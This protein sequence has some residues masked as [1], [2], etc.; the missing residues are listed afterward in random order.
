MDWFVLC[1]LQHALK[2]KIPSYP[3]APPEFT[4]L[5]LVIN[6]SDGSRLI[7]KLYHSCALLLPTHDLKL[8]LNWKT[9]LGQSLTDQM[10]TKCCTQTRLFFFNHRHKLLHFKFLRRAYATLASMDCI[11]PARTSECPRCRAMN[12]EF[13]HKAWLC[14]GVASFWVEI[15]NRLTRLLSPPPRYSCYWVMFKTFL[16]QCA[17]TLSF[18]FSWRNERW[19]FIGAA[20][21]HPGLE[22]GFAASLTVTR[23]VSCTQLYNPLLHV[24]RKSG[25]HWDIICVLF[26][27][28]HP[29]NECTGT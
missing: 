24:L 13:I 5:T 16:N 21:A 15:F 14:L 4:P 3:L 11:D 20:D 17:D 29:H 9:D 2:A 19:P 25:D 7:F 26:P 28:P 12:A 23:L 10:W 8:Q 22:H 27:H 6:A 1:R 18:P